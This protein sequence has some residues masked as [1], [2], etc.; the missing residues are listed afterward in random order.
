V[1]ELSETGCYLGQ[2]GTGGSEGGQLSLDEPMGLAIG[3]GCELWVTDPGNDRVKEWDPFDPRQVTTTYDKLGRPIEYVDA[4]GK[5]S[6]VSYDVLGVV[7]KHVVHP[8]L[9][10]GWGCSS[11][12]DPRRPD[13]AP[14]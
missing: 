7:P 3:A 8:D 9:L 14:R 4:E 6:S 12:P 10:G 11:H 1:H 5:N 2:L 13:E